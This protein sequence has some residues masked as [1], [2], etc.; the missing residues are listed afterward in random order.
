MFSDHM[1]LVAAILDSTGTEHPAFSSPRK[2]LVDRIDLPVTLSGWNEKPLKDFK[3]E[4]NMARY[5]L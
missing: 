1:W 3:K 4:S 2:V 5:L